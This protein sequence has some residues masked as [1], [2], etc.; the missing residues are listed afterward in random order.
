VRLELCGEIFSLHEMKLNQCAGVFKLMIHFINAHSHQHGNACENDLEMVCNSMIWSL[1]T[2]E[3][4]LLL[5][6]RV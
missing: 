2:Y 3:R 1:I 4:A 5:S 6:R